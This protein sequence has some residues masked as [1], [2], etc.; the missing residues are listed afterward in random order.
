M[1]QSLSGAPAARYC[2]PIVAQRKRDIIGEFYDI[3]EEM[4]EYCAF[5]I[6]R[7]TAGMSDPI[8]TRFRHQDFDG[9]TAFAHLLRATENVQVDIETSPNQ[10]SGWALFVATL[11][12][13]LHGLRRRLPMRWRRLNE[14]WR[15]VPGASTRPTAYAWSLFSK[16]E[17]RRLGELARSRGVSLQAWLL[18]A[19]K[20][21]IVPELV[22]G[23][24]FVSWHVPVNM[25]GAFPGEADS[26]NCNFSLEVTVP[27]ET[28]P[29]DVHRA[30]RQELRLRRHWIVAKTTFWFGRRIGRG[31]FRKLVE[32]AFWRQQPWQG[33]FSSSGAVAPEDDNQQ[34]D[35][36]EWFIGLNPVV[37]SSPLGAC[38]AE[39]RG[40]MA[41]SLQIHPSLA[42]D[43]QVA[44]DWM[45][46]W[47][48]Y[49][50]GR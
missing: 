48:K 12:L 10:P 31:L 2:L 39:W 29:Q 37:R 5:H 14:S 43:A 42:T 45:A 21:A 49:A 38:C 30:I 3:L 19:L 26:G 33:S 23:S 13:V 47:R 32:S 6:G 18:W 8:W 44:R 1:S 50:E 11:R 46:S 7:Y 25:H 35:V 4:G 15:P 16:E 28:G 27:P 24:G 41:L 36:D 34:N 17:T 20:E 40:R 9:P 22:P